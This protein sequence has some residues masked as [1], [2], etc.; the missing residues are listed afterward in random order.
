[1]D[2]LARFSANDYRFLL[3]DGK[4]RVLSITDS[5]CSGFFGV[6]PYPTIPHK[7]AALLYHLVLDHLM[8]DGNKRFAVALLE[9]FLAKNGCIWEVS[10]EEYVKVPVGIADRDSRPTIGQLCDLMDATVRCYQLG[11]DSALPAPYDPTS[12]S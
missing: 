4:Q 5:V 1:M 6:D 3:P 10:S 2:K 12:G 7:A 8:V 11:A 9:L